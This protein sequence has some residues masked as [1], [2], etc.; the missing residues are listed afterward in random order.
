ME[1]SNNKNNSN[2]ISASPF[3]Q[4]SFHGTKADL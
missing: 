4:T 2:G 1:K 3:A